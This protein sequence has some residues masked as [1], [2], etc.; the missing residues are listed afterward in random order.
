MLL[1]CGLAQKL[2]S[3]SRKQQRHVTIIRTV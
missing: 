1:K 2:Q 3:C